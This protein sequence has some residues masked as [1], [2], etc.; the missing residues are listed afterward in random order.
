M[1]FLRHTNFYNAFKTTQRLNLFSTSLP[2]VPLH[3][4]CKN[5]RFQDQSAYTKTIPN[6]YLPRLRNNNDLDIFRRIS[7]SHHT[8]A[9]KTNLFSQI[10]SDIDPYARLIRFD[11]PIGKDI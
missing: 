9:N 1:N 7:S 5:N 10:K 11:R 4:D 2:C 6:H 8:V 3:N